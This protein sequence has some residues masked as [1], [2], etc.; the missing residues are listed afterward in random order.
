MEATMPL[1]GT[2]TL[3]SLG[4]PVDAILD[5]K[6]EIKVTYSKTNPKPAAKPA[7]PNKP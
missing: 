7:E 5:Q 1:E 4:Q 6:Q 2:L 3:S